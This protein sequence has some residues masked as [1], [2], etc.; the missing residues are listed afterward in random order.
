MS[1]TL[2][3]LFLLLSLSFQMKLSIAILS[4]KQPVWNFQN[5]FASILQFLKVL[6]KSSENIFVEVSSGKFQA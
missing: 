1:M 6:V 2:F 4:K 5:L 3:S